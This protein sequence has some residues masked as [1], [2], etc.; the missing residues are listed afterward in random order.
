[1][2]IASSKFACAQSYDVEDTGQHF[3]FVLDLRSSSNLN[4]LPC[5]CMYS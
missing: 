4:V 1:M 5:N 3:V 2:D